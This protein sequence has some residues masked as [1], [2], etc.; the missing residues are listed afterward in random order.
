MEKYGSIHEG[1]AELN[2]RNVG[3]KKVHALLT[4]Q[5]SNSK[6]SRDCF[7][8]ESI[9]GAA[10]QLIKKYDQLKLSNISRIDMPGAI[11]AR[12]VA[13]NAELMEG[14]PDELGVVQE[15]HAEEF[16]INYF[17]TAVAMVKD[18]KFV[19]IYVTHSP[20]TV[21]DAKPSRSLPGWPKSCT[22]KLSKLASD[23]PEYHF[24]IVFLQKFGMLASN[25]APQTMLKQLSGEMV[26]LSFVDSNATPP[27]ERL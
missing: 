3:N 14:D 12:N 15:G 1:L 10:S 22:A 24:S 8:F 16:L 9:E 7:L 26:N 20:C 23:H 21:H 19:T 18:I 5:H 27:Y 13:I 25:K 2:K 17:T 6:A 11:E 4:F